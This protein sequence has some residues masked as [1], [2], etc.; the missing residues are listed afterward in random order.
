LYDRSESCGRKVWCTNFCVWKYSSLHCLKLLVV[1][2]FTIHP[3]IPTAEFWFCFLDPIWKSK[4]P[5]NFNAASSETFFNVVHSLFIQIEYDVNDAFNEYD[6]LLFVWTDKVTLM[7]V[8]K[9]N[10]NALCQFRSMK[11]RNEEFLS[12]FDMMVLVLFDIH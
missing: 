10:T 1:L 2:Y 9:L 12:T 11:R 6:D 4:L 5:S 3:P 7:Q 8:S